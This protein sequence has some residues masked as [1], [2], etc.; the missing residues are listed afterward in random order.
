MKKWRKLI[1]RSTYHVVHIRKSEMMT[2]GLDD[3]SVEYEYTVYPQA[4]NKFLVVLR[5]K[6][7]KEKK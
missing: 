5:E 6:D 2:L 3:F 1:T 4:P 7:E